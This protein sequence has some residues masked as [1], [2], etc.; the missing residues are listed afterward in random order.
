MNV[1]GR[2]IA[3]DEFFKNFQGKTEE[4]LLRCNQKKVTYRSGRFKVKSHDKKYYII[5]LKYD[6]EEEY[7][8]LIAS[9]SSWLD[10][11][12]IKAYSLR[13]LVEVF[14]QDWKS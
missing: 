13:W 2:N 6:D 3:V 9:D 7:R 4:V 11:D 10:I 8:Y 1:N 14:I 5:A 12:I